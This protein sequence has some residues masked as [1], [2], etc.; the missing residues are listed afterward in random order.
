M[1][2]SDFLHLINSY[3]ETHNLTYYEVES[4]QYHGCDDSAYI[5]LTVDGYDVELT[6]PIKNR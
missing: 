1:K 2:I 6:V 4:F 5:N 3:C